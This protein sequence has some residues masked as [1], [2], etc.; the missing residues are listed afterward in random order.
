MENQ[1]SNHE[2]LHRQAT[3]LISKLFNYF[4]QQVSRFGHSFA[5]LQWY[6]AES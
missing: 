1:G 3:D 4:K 5:K 2:I 6:T